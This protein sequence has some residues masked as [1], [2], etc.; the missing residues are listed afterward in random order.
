LDED[1]LAVESLAGL[2]GGFGMSADPAAAEYESRVGCDMIVRARLI[3]VLRWMT[4]RLY[5]VVQ[6]IHELAERVYK[7]PLSMT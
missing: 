1:W 5:M 6:A 2:G 3:I 7:S 4:E